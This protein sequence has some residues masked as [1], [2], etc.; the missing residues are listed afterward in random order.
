LSV[1]GILREQTQLLIAMVQASTQQDEAQL[2]AA[3]IR[4]KRILGEIAMLK[5]LNKNQFAVEQSNDNITG[6]S[7]HVS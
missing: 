7:I 3:Q 5:H 1:I 6:F 2:T 4:Q